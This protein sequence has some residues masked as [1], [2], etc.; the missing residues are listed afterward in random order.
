MAGSTQ[1]LRSP[2][3]RLLAGLVFTLL[4]IGLYAA[5]TLRTVDRMREVQ[6]G[7]VERNRLASLQLIRIQ[8]ELHA[9]GLSM[10][11]MLDNREGYGL[12]A[13][14]P[15]LERVRFNLDHAI[16]REAELTGARRTAQQSMY[17][18]TSFT[19]F[20]DTAERMLQ[21]AAQGREPAARETVRDTLQ[22]QQEALTALVARLLVEANERD[23]Q[24]GLEIEGIYGGMERNA[25]LLL[26]I[27]VFAIALTSLM[28]IRA[29]RDLFSRLATL[30]QERRDLAQ[31]LIT[32]Q[33]ST[34]RSVSRDLHDE[35]G[36]I[37]TAIG[38]LLR[39]A[40][41]HAGSPALEDAVQEVSQVVQQTLEKTRSLS[42]ALQPVILEE[43]GLLAAVAWHLA[44]FRDHTGMAVTSR[45]PTADPAIA[46]EKA[47]HVFRILQEALNNVVRHAG[48]N[49][50]HVEMETTADRLRLVVA[51]AGR[52]I[53]AGN[54]VGVGLA[55]MRERAELVGGELRIT[56]SA[57]AGTSV[58]LEMPLPGV[59]EGHKTEEIPHA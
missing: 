39:R 12:T 42:Q 27:S 55:A 32:T 40:R 11:D 16:T 2:T 50:V 41:R 3:P 21:L 52:G 1:P 51:D 57:D 20:W 37:L 47:I 10:R 17:L 33:E 8:S 54:A 29:N 13:W 35:F 30:A 38:A 23:S 48:V 44:T 25:W 6:R 7:I 15:A 58:T 28:L 24:A 19:T 4:V 56:S 5:Y 26:A 49:A 14:R 43:Q 53:V 31:Q 45:L 22:P 36:Q 34:L 59:V 46:P 18:R 9:L